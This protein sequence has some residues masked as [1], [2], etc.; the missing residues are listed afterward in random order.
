VRLSGTV[1]QCMSGGMSFY[2][3]VDFNNGMSIFAVSLNSN[4]NQMLRY[5]KLF[6]ISA[7]VVG[8]CVYWP[9]VI[10]AH[11]I[12]S[13]SF[14]QEAAKQILLREA[15]LVEY[16]CLSKI[17]P[18]IGEVNIPKAWEKALNSAIAMKS[19]AGE[20]S[21]LYA[22]FRKHTDELSKL[23]KGKAVYE[24]SDGLHYLA[25]IPSESPNWFI[26]IAKPAS[27]L[28]LVIATPNA[29]IFSPLLTA[30]IFGLVGAV[31]ITLTARFTLINS[32]VPKE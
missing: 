31:L 18:T 22:A 10:F 19:S 30:F 2:G 27:A 26:V 1:N 25:Y 16:F 28:K 5:L 23:T 12:N 15:K 32:A 20:V 13:S 24:Q 17:P 4:E 9:L 11:K 14:T 29:G 21:G 7:I 6:C 8:I 3:S